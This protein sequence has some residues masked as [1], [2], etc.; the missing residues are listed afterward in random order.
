MKR[1]YVLAALALAGC[2]QAGT[3][4]DTP[5]EPT[6]IDMVSAGDAKACASVQAES[7][8]RSIVEE[9]RKRYFLSSQPEDLKTSLDMVTLDTSVPETR[10]LVC[11]ATWYVDYEGE[12]LTSIPIM[13]ALQP[14]VQGKDVVVEVLGIN[15]VRNDYGRANLRAQM[16]RRQSEREASAATSDVAS[17]DTSSQIVDRAQALC[18]RVQSAGQITG[19][20]RAQADQFI[21]E[22]RGTTDERSGDV[23]ECM[24]QV[25]TLPAAG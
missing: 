19:D 4:A 14:D 3:N 24:R 11:K 17:E 5:S 16:I 10:R 12:R 21:E 15:G 18:S 9:A 1:R 13:F 7:V 25:L 20:E 8:V 23:S 6:L 2:G 22:L